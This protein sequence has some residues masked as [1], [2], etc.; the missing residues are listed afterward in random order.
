MAHM[1]ETMAYA[2]EVPWHGLGK[3]VPADLSPEQMLE[4]A[5]LDWDVSKFPLYAEVGDEEVVVPGREA[6]IRS[7]DNQV[8]DIVGTDWNPL[9]N[10]EA[11]EFF[12]DF[13]S[14]GDMEMHT[15]GSLDDG[16]RVWALAKVN[17]AFEVFKGDVVEQFLLFSNPHKYGESIDVRMTPVRVVCNN[18]LTLALGAAAS[19]MV[20]VSH[21]NVFDADDVKRTLGVAAEKLTQ[22][23]EAARFLGKKKFQQE[24]VVEYFDRL[25]PTGTNNKKDGKIVKLSR[26]AALAEEILNTQPGHEFGEGT[27]WSAF[28][29][30]TYLTD[31][32]LGRSNENRMKSS[33]FGYNKKRKESAL[34]LALEYAEAA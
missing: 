20:K 7:S 19:N 16:R 3:K 33:W 30:V 14:A 22:Y 23:K 10:S 28:N 15:A 27:W 31:H 17:D 2:G 11:F 32:V 29:S 34:K 4:A 24:S 8:L 12:N 5:G 13:V 9:Q 18:T 26:T 25:F 21:R 6:L 1:V